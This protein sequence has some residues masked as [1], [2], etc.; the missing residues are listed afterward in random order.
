MKID[1]NK[2]SFT[3]QQHGMASLKTGYSIYN[4]EQKKRQLKNQLSELYP[5]LPSEKFQII[6]ADP[7]WDYGGKMQFD[8]SSDF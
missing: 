3:E 6:Y 5:A 1:L 2:L 8:K 4:E 7:P